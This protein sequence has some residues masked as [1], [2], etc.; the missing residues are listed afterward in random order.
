LSDPQHRRSSPHRIT[1]D[2]NALRPFTKCIEVDYSS[3]V[4]GNEPEPQEIEIAWL[5]GVDV[6][7]WSG[8]APSG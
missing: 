7:S 1:A 4:K 8:A 2:A 3:E 5:G 6:T